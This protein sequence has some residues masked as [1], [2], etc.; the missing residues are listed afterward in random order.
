MN[1]Y[2]QHYIDSAQVQAQYASKLN[3][4]DCAEGAMKCLNGAIRA[5]TMA[6]RG[7]KQKES[8]GTLSQIA[9]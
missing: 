4:V 7:I 1:E 2:I 9:E 3:R 6:Y 5:L 8:V